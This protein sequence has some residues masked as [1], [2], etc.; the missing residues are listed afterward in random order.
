MTISVNIQFW[1]VYYHQLSLAYE[2]QWG[3]INMFLDHLTLK[4]VDTN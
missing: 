2:Q 4:I 1:I 3:L